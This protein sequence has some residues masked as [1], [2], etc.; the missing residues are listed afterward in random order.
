MPKPLALIIEDDKN[1]SRIFSLALQAD[2]ETEVI[3]DGSTALFR[4]PNILP[5][6][7]VLD[8]NLPGLNGKAILSDIR[9]D[10]RLAKTKVILCTADERQ[11]EL[12]REDADIV[13]LKPVSPGQLR[14]VAS[15]FLPG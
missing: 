13:M 11:A 7:V 14:Q 3:S 8:L 12:V 6:L 9:A 2:F 1:L 10:P 4:I 5:T 15:R